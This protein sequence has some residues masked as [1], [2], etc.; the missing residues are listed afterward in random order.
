MR[1]DADKYNFQV[2]D[3]IKIKLNLNENVLSCFKNNK[4]FDS[5]KLKPNTAYF[6]VIVSM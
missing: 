3:I 4:K 5:M 2:N 6:L 1:Q